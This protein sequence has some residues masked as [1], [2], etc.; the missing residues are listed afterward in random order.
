LKYFTI[1]LVTLT[2]ILLIGVTGDFPDWGD[3][4]APA[5]VHLSP[6]YLQNAYKDT[7]TPNVVTAV[8]GDYRGFDTML[9]TSVVLI[10]GI[11][12]MALLRRVALGDEDEE[13]VTESQEHEPYES[14][15]IVRVSCDLLIPPMQLFALY[16]LM[17]GHYSPG[18]GFQGGVILGATLILHSLAYG[19]EET[20][21]YFSERVTFISSYFGVILYS[22]IGLLC[23]FF[24][25]N[26]LDYGSLDSILPGV[27]S[28]AR[29][30]AVLGIETGVAITVMAVMFSIYADL[31]S[32]GR[33]DKG[34]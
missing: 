1:L 2:G 27:T 17:H 33:F 14:T 19:L 22:G 8:L 4:K 7:H 20:L 34:L 23:L 9:E 31:A 28:S 25:A 13:V 11:A 26:F 15:P 16:V 3:P 18:G 12:I 29:S 10:A 5:S 21:K 6:Y 24:G 30:F 32:L